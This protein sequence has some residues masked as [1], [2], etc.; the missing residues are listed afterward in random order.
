[1]SEELEYL[2]NIA[3][4]FDEEGWAFV[5]RSLEK[6]HDTLVEALV[7][8]DHVAEQKRGRIKALN[9]VL[10]LPEQVRARIRQLEEEEV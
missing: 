5:A 2:R 8:N 1:M 3:H 4:F 10:G 6:D 7:D 9:D